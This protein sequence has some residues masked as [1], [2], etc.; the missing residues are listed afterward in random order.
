M[1]ATPQTIGATRSR[2]A[3]ARSAKRETTAR[4]RAHAVG[5][6]WSRLRLNERSTID[7]LDQY[8]RGS[9]VDRNQKGVQLLTE[10]D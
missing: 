8:R 9:A 2:W 4:K 1:Q 6:V 5:C 10:N 3:H 7:R